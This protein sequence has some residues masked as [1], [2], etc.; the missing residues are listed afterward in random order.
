V[1]A[2][3]VRT[4]TPERDEKRMMSLR[5]DGPLYRLIMTG[6][7]MSIEDGGLWFLKKLG[8]ENPILSP[9]CSF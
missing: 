5:N 4:D 7:G 3:K 1:R 9:H 8:V 2:A 6:M